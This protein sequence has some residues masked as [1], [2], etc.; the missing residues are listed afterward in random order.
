MS[1]QMKLELLEHGTLLLILTTCL[2]PALLALF[3]Y[4]SSS[5]RQPSRSAPPPP[6]GC[7]KLGLDGPS[8]L[9][10]EFDDAP[11]LP[12][13][14][15]SSPSSSSS[16]SSSS[17]QPA[18]AWTVKS[19][20]IYPVK[21]CAGVELASGAVVATGMA[22][23][24]QFSLAQLKPAAAGRGPTWTFLTQR[25]HS[26]LAQVQTEIWVPDAA[27]PDSVCRAAVLVISF[28]DPDRDPDDS[29][30]RRLA[31]RLG[32]LRAAPQP[33][34]RPRRSFHVPFDPTPAQIQRAGYPSEHMSI[35]KDAPL[36]LNMSAHLPPGLARFLALAHPL[37][38][39]RVQHGHERA[40]YRC[41]PRKEQL[42]W[43]PVTGFA[44]AYPL[45]L[46]SLGSVRDV[47]RHVHDAIPRLAVIRFRPNIIIASPDAPPYA[48]DGWKTI[49]IGAHVYFVA[50]RT[51]RCRVPNVDPAT[52]V[53][54]PV[55]P[56]R[57]M[58]RFRRVDRGA[59]EFACLGVQMVPARPD[60][61]VCV[62][63]RVEVLETGEHYYIRQ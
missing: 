55:E 13:P 7:R 48:E 62:G 40:V 39:F 52:G 14:D 47:N 15:S 61:V 5:L 54:H 44:D 21:S 43:Q 63:D 1:A 18:V 36:A 12:G 57:A 10:D 24:R 46:I 58:R 59:K 31:R 41:A 50:C 3:I 32:G 60:G 19:L 45:H 4:G 33:Q 22:Y 8:A 51:A 9:S 56:D 49:R 42:G 38:L 20:W 35:W 2:C 25:E 11:S 23:D 16:S 30:W 28:P 29:R 6:P 26:M 34:P 27:S 37:A 53:R 17:P